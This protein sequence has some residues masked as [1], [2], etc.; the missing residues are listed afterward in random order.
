MGEIL[1]FFMSKKFSLHLSSL[2]S[3]VGIFAVCAVRVIAESEIM[4]EF[5][6]EDANAESSTADVDLRVLL[7]D[8]TTVMIAVKRN[9]NASQVYSVMLCI[10]HV[11]W[12]SP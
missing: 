6:M 2:F 9:S 11:F 10:H 1:G 7:P 8:Q 4:Q 12:L 5:L 3:I